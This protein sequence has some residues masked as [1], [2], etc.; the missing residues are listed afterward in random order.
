MT[1]LLSLLLTCVVALFVMVCY[2]AL[3]EPPSPYA[4]CRQAALHRGFPDVQF[5]AGKCYG[6]NTSTAV[7]LKLKEEDVCLGSR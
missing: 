1:R 2:R 5:V 3:T 7:H 6:T 4:R